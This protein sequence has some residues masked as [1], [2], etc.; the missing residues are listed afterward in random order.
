MNTHRTG[1][2]AEVKIVYNGE[3]VGSEQ[4]QNNYS[5]RLSPSFLIL[6]VAKKGRKASK[7][8]DCLR[9]F[10]GLHLSSAIR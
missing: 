3:T 9:H 2:G 10:F 6:S 1:E 5:P 7:K 8:G 4:R